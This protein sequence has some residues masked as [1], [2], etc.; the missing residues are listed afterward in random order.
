MEENSS[1]EFETDVYLEKLLRL[2]ASDPI[3]LNVLP[4][5]VRNIVE[6]YEREREA[7]KRD[8]FRELA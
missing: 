3:G 1:T 7:A 4:E 2:R 8:S 6:H 5:A